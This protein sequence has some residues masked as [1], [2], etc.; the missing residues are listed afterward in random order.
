[1]AALTSP[2]I[3]GTLGSVI[4]G[5]YGAATGSKDQTIKNRVK[6]GVLGAAAGGA[7]GVG[8]GHVGKKL[9]S[10]F[11][12]PKP[13]GAR[14]GVLDMPP[15][16]R[17]SEA[18]LMEFDFTGMDPT[19][20]NKRAR[21][22][23]RENHPDRFINATPEAKLEAQRRFSRIADIRDRAMAA[24]AEGDPQKVASCAHEMLRYSFFSE[25]VK[26]APVRGATESW[27]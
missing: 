18:E 4:G 12:T 3:H 1:M 13:I 11:A 26:H 17:P 8:G 6:R 2:G 10:A 19:Q 25:V 22:L 9:H 21:K 23:L 27:W 24:A 5:A 14:E 16:V 20:L 15:I 7:L